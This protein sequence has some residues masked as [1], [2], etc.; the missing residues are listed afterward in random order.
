[1]AKREWNGY[2]KHVVYPNIEK[3]V[4]AHYHNYSEFAE[5]I[6]YHRTTIYGLMSGTKEPHKP[7]ID[8][9]LYMTGMT[10]EVAFKRGGSHV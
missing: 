10:Y 8:V 4:K 5:A 1:M 2:M 9:I 7:L 3:W 6:G